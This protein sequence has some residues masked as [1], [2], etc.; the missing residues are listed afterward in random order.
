MCRVFGC[1][2]VS[3]APE[4]LREVSRRQIHGGPDAQAMVRGGSWAL[5]V[6]RLAVV[7]PA[8]GAQPYTLGDGLTAVFN[9]EISN[10]RELRRLLARRGHTVPGRCDGAV[11]PAL[12]AEYGPG[13]VRLFDGMFALALADTRAAPL[14]LLATDPAG[15]KPLHYSW[16]EDRKELYFSSELPALLEFGE[17][18]TVADLLL[19]G[20]P[21]DCARCDSRSYDV[22]L[23]S[24]GNPYVFLRADQLGLAG[25]R[26][27]FAA[28]DRVLGRM[29]R[30]RETAA[31]LMKCRMPWPGSSA[32][33]RDR[34]ASRRR[35]ASRPS[36]RTAPA[37]S[38]AR[39]PSRGKRSP[40][41]PPGPRRRPSP[42]SEGMS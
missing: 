16:R 5:G 37:A 14:L 28:D 40:S 20:C 23:V 24:M 33:R 41:C 11:I 19:T 18:G 42:R 27:L 7:D 35:A 34:C 32:C 6:N 29:L 36:T 9:G 22:S 1:F 8:G 17:I 10:H 30:I 3:P 15:M 12:Y 26:E 31:R 38:S 25:R 13:F 39:P 21:V 2:G 4:T